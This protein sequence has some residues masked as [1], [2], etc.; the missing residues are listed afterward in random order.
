MKRT[1]IGLLLGLS[2][3]YASS[4]QMLTQTIRGQVLDETSEYSLPGA[5]V[6]LLETNPLLG[7]TTDVNGYFEIKNVPLGR[8]QAVATYVGY[9][10]FS[11]SDIVVH[12]GKSTFLSIKLKESLEQLDEI[13]VKG[14]RPKDL[15]LNDMAMVSART[16]SVE[17]TERYAGGLDDPARMATAFAGVSS[18]S[19]SENAIVVRGNSPKGVQWRME[20]IE[21]PSPSHFAGATTA[22]GGFVTLLSNHV[23][24]N[25]D[26]LT[27]AFP[28]EYG[29][30][31]SGVFDMNLRRGNNQ[32]YEHTFKAG[33]L[34]IDFA[35]EGPLSR[36][37]KGSYLFNY[38]YSTL[39]IIQPILPEDANTIRYQDL[40]F[41]L[42]FPTSIGE[43]SIWGIGGNDF[44]EKNQDLITDPGEWET[45]E[46]FTD[47]RF[48][49][50]VGAL[51]LMHK[52]NFSSNTLLKTSI[53]ASAN[54]AFW[55]MD[56][57]NA[58]SELSPE[59]RLSTLTGTH[60]VSSILSHKFSNKL[61]T[62]S[63]VLIHRHF[64]NLKIR[65][66]ADHSSTLRAIVLDAGFSHRMQAFSQT[67][68]RLSKDFEAMVG[69]HSQ[70]FA[71]NEEFSLEPRASL[72]W[73]LTNTKSISLG[74]GN[75]S[76][77]ED[78]KIYLLRDQ[79]GNQPNDKLG[80]ARA[81]HF[82]MSY[83]WLLT[84]NIRVKIEPYIQY[85]YNVPVIADS[86]YSMLNF[87]QDWFFDQKLE[88]TGAGQNY[89]LDMTMEKFLSDNYYFLITGSIFKSK[90]RGGDHIWRDTRF[91]R[92][93]AF[94]ALAGSEW[95]LGPSE[96]KWLG[97][98]LGLNLMGG[99]RR[100]P[101]DEV[102]SI[103]S[104]QEVLDENR[105][106]E[107]KEPSVYYLD[108]NLTY[109]INKSGHSSV[110]GLQIKNLM[111]SPDYGGYVYNYQTNTMQENQVSF[112]IPN[113][114]YKIE[115]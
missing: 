11:L 88:N 84:D 106:F 102:A 92:G 1:M 89:G 47:T 66:A 65:Q 58:N 82:V 80:F 59:H 55:E 24:D 25:S 90:Y 29:N 53:V 100:S 104:R 45:E 15:P 79:D 6:I 93:Y 114:S 36:K 54:D 46:D 63:G 70:Y 4:A 109:R 101:L 76:Q 37:N 94:N 85:L 38:R 40:S 99:L 108:L 50:N 21:I 35:S 115:F 7:A 68:L 72:K 22:G 111:G 61:S 96:T 69:L 10:P 31:I 20:G 81:N 32:A 67:K 41:K 49:F 14:D 51:G 105:A 18:A 9:E 91:N 97:L 26:F 39:G 30:A 64:Y 74:Y 87:K 107:S 42:N 113:L 28:A 13:I 60:S 103:A 17:E 43:F 16:F 73:N 2:M 5:T 75:H 19:I 57:L 77:M 12:S 86:S 56:K 112:M 23:L 110:W 34:G 83:D 27:G 8:Y 78:A 62:R 98:N 52:M 48:G 95:Q 33:L 3:I 71:L 44:G